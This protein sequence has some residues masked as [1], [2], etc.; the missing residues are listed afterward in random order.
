MKLQS[1]QMKHNFHIEI[2]RD[3]DAKLLTPGIDHLRELILGHEQM[4]PNID[5]WFAKK[6]LPG[7]RSTEKMAFL[8]YLDEKPIISAVV[9]KGDNSKFCHLHLDSEI[10]D[11]HLGELF[12]L[13]MANE[14]RGVAKEI[15]FTL[16][17]SL[18]IKEQNFFRSFGFDKF[19][20]AND[21][22]RLFDEELRCSS[23]FDKV[24]KSVIDKLPKLA[25]L[26]S[27]G[28]YSMD[29]K[30]LLS[31]KPEFA[32]RIVIGSKRVEIRR[33]FAK[34]WEGYNVCLY[35]SRG[36]SAL[37]GEA[38]IE[39]IDNGSPEDIW[40]R[41]S[42]EI[43]S[44]Q[45]EFWEYVG[46]AKEVYAIILTDVKPYKAS[47]PISQLSHILDNE[48]KPPQSYFLLD[49]NLNWSQAVSVAALLH[50]DFRF[51]FSGSIDNGK[52]F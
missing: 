6:V 25:S 21:Q 9:K 28:G 29:N 13:L 34:K 30:I 12:F 51:K 42:S 47:V 36:E 18:W 24:W 5:K 35:S 1:D 41:Y 26:Y 38:R 31:L 17:E 15:H 48:L 2:L 45:D 4:Y 33:K 49:N 52:E 46:M 23:P 16:P 7:L 14:V 43:G 19:V 32:R 10:K 50:A 40:I 22:Y 3:K 11:H 39:M 44:T 20:K 8:G 37:V 27:I